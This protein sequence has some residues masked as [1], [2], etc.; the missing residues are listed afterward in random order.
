MDVCSRLFCVCVTHSMDRPP[1]LGALLNVNKN[2]IVLGVNCQVQEPRR[3]N[4]QQKNKKRMWRMVTEI[5]S[6]G[7]SLPR[8]DLFS[9]KFR[10]TILKISAI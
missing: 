5:D 2:I 10:N 6:L 3:S 8:K 1:V 9:L 4:P 7:F